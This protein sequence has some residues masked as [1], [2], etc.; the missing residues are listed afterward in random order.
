MRHANAQP[1]LQSHETRAPRAPRALTVRDIMST[2]V[3]VLEP[4]LSLR[5]AITLLADRRITGAP[6][7]SAG[8]IMGTLSANDVL[9]FEADT[10]GVPLER[11]QQPEDDGSLAET[12][13][14]EEDEW[15]KE[16]EAPSAYFD[17]PWEDAGAGAEETF[18][19][20]NGPEWDI[21]QE[22]TVA[23][24]MSRGVRSVSPG[25]SVEEAAAYMLKKRIHRA[26]VLESGELVGI[27]TATDVMRAVANRRA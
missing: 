14:T 1:A 16:V 18:H 19:E 17:E 5:D 12:A 2:D 3:V 20:L 15:A 9:A 27:I 22:H 8:T 7:A 6:V 26:V 25:T 4:E 11:S 13:E 21:L 10:P 24:A 23:E